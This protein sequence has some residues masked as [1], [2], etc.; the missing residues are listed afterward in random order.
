MTNQHSQFEG[1]PLA[2]PEDDIEDQG[3]AFDAVTLL[4]RR[5]VLGALG[6]GVGT[7]ALAACGTAAT[8][9]STGGGST[10]SSESTRAGTTGTGTT[11]S[12]TEEIPE[13]TNGPYP[14]DG[15]RDLN[16]LT[17]S[18]IVRQDIRTSLDGGETA[19]GV[20]LTMTFVL[21]DMANGDQPFEGAAVY[22]WQCDGVGRY[23]MYTQGVEDQTWLR[24]VQVA[25]AEGSVSF[26]TIVPGCYSGRWPHIHFEV[27]PDLDS[28]TD[29]ENVI[30]TSQVAFPEDMLTEIYQL[31]EYVGSADNMAGVGSMQDDGIFADSYELQTPV[32]TGS[33]GE[34]YVATLPVG[35]DTTT[36][37]SSGGGPGGGGPGGG[38]PGG[39]QIVASR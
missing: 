11:T 30:A 8:G 37:P 21:A 3:A 9:E 1:R 24:G 2:R 26:T 12:A 13:E 5:R 19:E 18:G 14:A 36:E 27:Y 31:A 39:R 4:T 38:G 7:V 16:I 32:I 33:I 6:I 17:E 28:A 25:D 20:E 22:A 29:V 23:S 35:I 10:T 15:T 34:G